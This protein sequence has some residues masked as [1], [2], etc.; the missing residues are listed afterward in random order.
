MQDKEIN[1]LFD[2]C[3]D[4]SHSNINRAVVLSEFRAKLD[5]AH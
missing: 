4:F 1:V 3:T 5:F 2:K